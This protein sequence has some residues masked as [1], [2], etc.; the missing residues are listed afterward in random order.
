MA[1]IKHVMHL[2]DRLSLIKN[3][4]QQAEALMNL[5]HLLEQC[6]DA[7]RAL[8]LADESSLTHKYVRGRLP[9]WWDAPHLL[10]ELK[11]VN[12]TND[13]LCRVHEKSSPNSTCYIGNIHDTLKRTFKTSDRRTRLLAERY[14]YPAAHIH[15]YVSALCGT[16]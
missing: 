16:L 6:D 12:L 11:V 4:S 2:L 8:V 3:V 1:T 15:V 14:V 7:Q 5:S 13:M 10:Y 9:A